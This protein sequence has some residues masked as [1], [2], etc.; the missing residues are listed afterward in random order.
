MYH[1]WLTP[2]VAVGPAGAKGVGLFATRDF[3]EG[4]I[5]AGFGGHVMALRDFEQLPEDRQIHSL[6][7][8]EDLF[9][10]AP[11]ESEPADLFNHSCEPNLGIL[12][13]VLLVTMR[14]IVSG[15]E[16]TFDYA[17]C[18]ADSYDE[19]ECHCNKSTCRDKVTGNDWMLPELQRRYRGYFSTYLERRIDA[20]LAAPLTDSI[21]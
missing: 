8:A 12:G 17:M 13:N 4:E 3:T 2:D 6:Q 1:S 21:V 16:V 7:I 20:L 11:S 5:V 15:E 18:D 9:M 19:F 10:V 14:P